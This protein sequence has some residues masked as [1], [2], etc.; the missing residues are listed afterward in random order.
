MIRCLALAFCAFAFLF[1]GLQGSRP[2]GLGVWSP[3]SGSS[4]TA[5][6]HAAERPVRAPWPG[7]FRVEQIY[8][9][10]G[11]TVDVSF[12][13]GPCGAGPCVGQELAIR[14]AGVD[15][16]EL[17]MCGRTITPSCAA[18]PAEVA[19]GRMARNQLIYWLNGAA[20][21]VANIRPDKYSGRVIGD[22]QVLRDGVWQSTSQMLLAS[23][24]AVLYSGGKKTKPWCEA[25]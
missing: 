2:G 25:K 3:L 24:H 11:D 4:L 7:P 6:A 18:C 16:A 17:K 22:L 15:A 20:L 12:K 13:E 10:D 23:G 8:V 21:R 5:S 9:R 1:L 14:L 19:A